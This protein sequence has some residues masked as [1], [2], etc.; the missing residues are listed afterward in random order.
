MPIFSPFFPSFFYLPFPSFQFLLFLSQKVCP[1][2]ATG[3]EHGTQESIKFENYF[4]TKK[5]GTNS[6][7]SFSTYF[8]PVNQLFNLSSG[9]WNNLRKILRQSLNILVYSGRE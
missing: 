9:D 8:I 2:C 4:Q 6:N 7:V 1:P 5:T 3:L